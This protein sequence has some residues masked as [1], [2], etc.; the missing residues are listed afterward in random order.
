MRTRTF[1]NPGTA[2]EREI[3]RIDV[4]HLEPG[5]VVSIQTSGGGGYGNPLD[6]DPDF[7]IA[8]VRSGLLSSQAAEGHYGVRLRDDGPD[9]TATSAERVR[10]AAAMSPALFDLGPSRRTYETVW[11]PLL[12]E[13]LSEFLLTLPQPFRPYA[14]REIH[15][16]VDSR[17][18]SVSPAAIP[19]IWAEINSESTATMQRE[20]AL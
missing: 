13:S 2:Q 19:A 20:G 10:E 8:D 18:E 15:R 12:S 9:L 4:L 16:W 6:R 11:T 7:V 3:G 1:V 5:D 17:G 14:K